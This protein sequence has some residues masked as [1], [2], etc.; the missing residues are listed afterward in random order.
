MEQNCTKYMNMEWDMESTFLALQ[1]GHNFIYNGPL[2]C[3]I[4]QRNLFFEWKKVESKCTF[5]IP[6]L[7]F[8]T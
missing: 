7:D 5:C 4:F 8:K 6:H 3:L 1:T 2:T